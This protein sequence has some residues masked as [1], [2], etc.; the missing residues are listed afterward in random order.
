MTDKQDDDRQDKWFPT[1]KWRQT[2]Q[3]IIDKPKDFKRL[4]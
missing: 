4:S 1:S 2:G 3:M